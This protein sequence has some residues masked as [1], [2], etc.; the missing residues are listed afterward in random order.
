VLPGALPF[1]SSSSTLEARSA[2]NPTL[3]GPF[4]TIRLEDSGRFRFEGLLDREYVLRFWNPKTQVAFDAGPF[5]AGT[6]D[7]RL[8][9]PPADAWIHLSGRVIGHRGEP[10]EGAQLELILPISNAPL[11]PFKARL[12]KLPVTKD[13]HFE[14]AFLGGKLLELRVT[15][16]DLVD[17]T[18]PHPIDLA[19]EV[20]LALEV[21]SKYRFHVEVAPDSPA[22]RLVVLDPE[23]HPLSIK[24][25]LTTGSIFNEFALRRDTGFPVAEVTDEAAELVLFAGDQELSRMP[26]EP[27]RGQVVTL[28]P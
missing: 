13:G 12:V 18:W 11:A 3:V 6:Q 10:L 1:G 20:P 8:T 24:S 23:G 16:P 27:R 15:G 25:M 9:I 5:P 17:R 14:L 19:A 7:L 22:D 4:G 2:S 21:L 28:R 26:L